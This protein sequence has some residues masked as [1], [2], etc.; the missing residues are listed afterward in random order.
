MSVKKPRHIHGVCMGTVAWGWRAAPGDPSTGQQLQ[1]GG[2]PLQQCMFSISLPSSKLL[3][4]T[5]SPPDTL[6]SPQIHKAT[7]G[8]EGRGQEKSAALCPLSSLDKKDPMGW[9]QTNAVPP[10]VTHYTSGKKQWTGCTAGPFEAA[11]HWTLYVL[12]STLSAF[13]SFLIAI[14]MEKHLWNVYAWHFWDEFPALVHLF[15]QQ[16]GIYLGVC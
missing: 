13:P 15:Q 5:W 11:H 8:H 4:Q 14:E 10:G 12:N 1:V 16:L 6:L 9:W 3:K 7:A 2:C